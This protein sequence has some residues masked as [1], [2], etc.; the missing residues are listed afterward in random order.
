MPYY[1]LT[2]YDMPE[3]ISSPIFLIIA[4]ILAV[5]LLIGIVKG[6]V[7]LFIWVAIIAVILIGLGVMTQEDMRD[8]FE[9]LL[10]RVTG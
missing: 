1:E 8:W 9:N 10:K 2:G 3:F 4:A 7:R 5:L 6:A